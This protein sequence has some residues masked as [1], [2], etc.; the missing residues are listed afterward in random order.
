MLRNAPR[1]ILFLSSYF[2]LAL[3]SAILVFPQ[4]ALVSSLILG[5]GLLSLFFAYWFFGG[6]MQHMQPAMATLATV[7]QK[8]MAYIMSYVF[9][10]VTLPMDSGYKIAAFGILLLLI[11]CLYM[12]S[13]MLH[14]NSSRGGL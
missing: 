4:S 3:I 14:I 11:C 9:P 5:M 1:F 13:N 12:N 10:F 8:D 7:E 2:P 6:H